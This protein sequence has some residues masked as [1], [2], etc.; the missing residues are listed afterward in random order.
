MHG[1]RIPLSPFQGVSHHN[2][3]WKMNTRFCRKTNYVGFATGRRS[4]H[5]STL[6][7]G[8]LDTMKYVD[9]TIVCSKSLITL[10]PHYIG[11]Q[12]NDAWIYI[13]ERPLDFD[14]T[15]P[16]TTPW[17]TIETITSFF[18]VLPMDRGT[19]R[20]AK[21]STISMP[22]SIKPQGAIQP[23]L[24]RPL[25]SCQLRSRDSLRQTNTL[26]TSSRSS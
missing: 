25:W 9:H 24:V 14:P 7:S 13:L 20:L 18:L 11:T 16:L 2:F 4:S 1:L 12:T 17:D 23:L 26:S 22:R 15:Y 3:E 5:W 10:S 21:S 19:K 6:Y 8:D